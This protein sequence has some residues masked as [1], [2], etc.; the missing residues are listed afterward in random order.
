MRPLVIKVGGAFL[1]HPEYHVDFFAHLKV[2]QA[3]QPVILV[4]G[5]GSLVANLLSAM[6]QTSEKRNGLRVTPVEQM[7]YVAA[8]L[9][10]QCNTQL[11]SAALSNGISATGITLADGQLTICHIEDETFG[12]VGTPVAHDATLINTLLSSGYL[13]IINSVGAT[14]TGQ[15]VNVNADYAATVIAALLDADLLLLSDVPGVLDADK[16]LINELDYATFAQH[17]DQG[18]ITDGMIVKV[19]AAI[20]TADTLGRPVT[21]GAWSNTAQLISGQ[22]NAFGTRVHPAKAT[23]K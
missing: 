16:A 11:L 12:C 23:A 4:H 17:V 6:G 15:L 2:L 10:G 5:G 21:I 7:P 3:S 18:V 14:A 19:Q 9:A 13:P 22:L 20:D 8:A 1:E